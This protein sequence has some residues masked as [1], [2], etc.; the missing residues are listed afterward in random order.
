MQWFKHQSNAHNDAKLEKVLM[1]YGAEGYALYWYCIELIAGKVSG[2][3]ITFELEHDSEILGFRLK[4]DSI[5]VEEIMKYMISLGLFENTDDRITCFKL[6][7]T[8]DE[9]WTRSEELKKVIKMSSDSLQTVYKPLPLDKNRI[10]K[11]THIQDEACKPACIESD[12]KPNETNLKWMSDS[13]LSESEQKTII[14]D[15]VD[16]WILSKTKR[17]NWDLTFRKNPI[18]NRKVNTSP[19]KTNGGTYEHQGYG[20]TI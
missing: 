4:V 5:R 13:G 7:A 15:F 17:K 19:K 11:K 18:V 9:R 14:R 10:D 2:S 12:W 1:K 16:F 3:N 8:L 6:A 20:E